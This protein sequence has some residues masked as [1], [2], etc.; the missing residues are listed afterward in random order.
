[1]TK[2]LKVNSRYR[3]DRYRKRKSFA[4]IPTFPWNIAITIFY[5]IR[6]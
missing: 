5:R 2:Q 1:M 3:E 4:Y 6:K